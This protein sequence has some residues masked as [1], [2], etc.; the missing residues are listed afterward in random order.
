MI[1]TGRLAVA[2]VLYLVFQEVQ[3][4]GVDDRRKTLEG[5]MRPKACSTASTALQELMKWKA[6]VRRAVTQGT[7]IPDPGILL[8][9]IKA[10]V[11]AVKFES[12]AEFRMK[13]WFAA[14]QI[15]ELPTY[16]K[17]EQLVDLLEMELREHSLSHERQRPSQAAWAAWGGGGIG[18]GGQGNP[19]SKAATVKGGGTWGT[20]KTN[21]AG[22]DRCIFGRTDVGADLVLN[23][24]RS[25]IVQINFRRA[26]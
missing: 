17:I 19:Q 24:I 4:N 3:P 13:S 23:A 1:E 22:T 21:A 15:R 9:S 18:G 2:E 10:I 20:D 5:L 11:N 14:Q 16:P 12:E 25:M 7:V 8:E 26:A 6:R